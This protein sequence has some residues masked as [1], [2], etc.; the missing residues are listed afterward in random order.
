MIP[1]SLPQALAGSSFLLIFS[2]SSCTTSGESAERDTL[3]T[4]VGVYP[5]PPS[6]IERPRIGVPPFKTEGTGSSRE[7]DRIAADQITTL[8][9]QTDRFVV[10]ERTQLEQMLKEQNLEG[11]VKAGELARQGQVR[12]VD[13]LLIGKVTNL[14]VKGENSASGFNLGRLPIPGTHG[15]AG[16]FDWKNKDSK[17]TSEC[18]VDLRIVNPTDGVVFAAQQ[19]EFKRTDTIGSVGI[20]V[21]GA[22]STA[23]ANLQI[24]EDDK[25]KILRLA[26]DDTIRKMLP[27]LDQAL[28]AQ[29]RAGARDATPAMGQPA[30]ASGPLA[31]TQ[32]G[33]EMGAGVKFCPGCGA[34]APEAAAKLFCSGCGKQVTADTK[35][36]GGCGAKVQ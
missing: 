11:I 19:S 16:L 29:A 30:T 32:C 7:L 35:F 31:C 23:G 13:Y 26:L 27:R 36:C 1:L 25:G 12:G 20:S 33:K 14:R 24:S 10:I 6:S 9:F 28:V 15:A 5:P 3:T 17:I 18:G 2:L 22:D 4:H 21:L 34:K 8:V